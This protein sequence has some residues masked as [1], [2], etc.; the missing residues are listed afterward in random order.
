MISSIVCRGYKTSKLVEL[1]RYDWVDDWITDELFPIQ[2]HRDVRRKIEFIQ[3]EYD[4]PSSKEV[5]KELVHHGLKRP[6]HEDA[7]EFGLQH[8][9][10]GT[11][12]IY[13]FLHEPVL[14]PIGLCGV[15]GVGGH[16]RRN[17][18]VH[19]FDRRWHRGDL[20]AGIRED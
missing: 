13:V 7:L 19:Q 8:P 12:W 2:P 6:T 5:L 15:L 18:G 14:M 4:N 17:L 10:A 9:S 1:A 20:F 11:P 3:C 16:G